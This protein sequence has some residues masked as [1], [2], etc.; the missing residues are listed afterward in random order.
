M[1]AQ[2][3]RLGRYCQEDELHGLW[4]LKQYV[5]LCKFLN[6]YVALT[7]CKL[8]SIDAVLPKCIIHISHRS[9]N[10]NDRTVE[11]RE[12]QGGIYFLNTSKTHIRMSMGL[13]TFKCNQNIKVSA[14]YYLTNEDFKLA[15]LGYKETAGI[16]GTDLFNTSS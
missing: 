13:E 9:C 14:S 2:N 10:I 3:Y 7:N 5:L 4:H 6:G 12:G 8:P 11:A 16:T 15:C 1:L